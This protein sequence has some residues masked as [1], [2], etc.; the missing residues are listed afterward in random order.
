MKFYSNFSLH[1]RKK[2]RKMTNREN[3]VC[4]T[5]VIV[6]AV[7]GFDSSDRCN[8]GGLCSNQ[9]YHAELLAGTIPPRS[10]VFEGKRFKLA[11][12]L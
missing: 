2:V 10:T 9:R 6:R 3:I 4:I 1:N 5:S 7:G 11:R 8:G 12:T